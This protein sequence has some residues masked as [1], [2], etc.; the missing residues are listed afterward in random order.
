MLMSFS[1][2]ASQ[3][4]FFQSRTLKEKEIMKFHW[5]SYS[6][7]SL[8]RLVS[9]TDTKLKIKLLK[10]LSCFTGTNEEKTFREFFLNLFLSI[11]ERFP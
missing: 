6:E 5:P 9:L 1:E 11:R 10:N 4:F 3:S 7:L 8:K 2:C